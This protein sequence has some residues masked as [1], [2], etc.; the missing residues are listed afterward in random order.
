L[1]LLSK[2]GGGSSNKLGSNETFQYL[3]KKVL[4]VMV[5]M[6]P[7]AREI[8]ID[9]TIKVLGC[10]QEQTYDGIQ[11]PQ[12]NQI[13]YIQSLPVS[14]G[15]YIPVNSIDFM[16]NLKISPDSIVGKF[17]YE[18][19]NP[20]NVLSGGTI[21]KPYGGTKNYPFNKMLNLRMDSNNIGRNYSQDFGAFYN[22]TSGQKLIDISYTQQNDLGVSGDFFRVFLINRDVGT[23]PSLSFRGD[24]VKQFLVDYYSTIKL[25]DPVTVISVL[26]NYASNFISIKG[27]FTYK[28]LSDD[29]A[30]ERILSRVL[31]LCN[32]NRREIDVSGIAKLA[33][34]D[35]VDDS[36]FELNEVDLRNIE[37]KIS[38]I[39]LGIVQYESCGDVSLPVPVD[40]LVDNINDLREIS[41]SLNPEEMVSS[42]EEIIDGY[43]QNPSWKPLLPND[44]KI[45]I[46]INKDIIKD[47]PKAIASSI[48]TPKILLPVFVL[49]QS[50]EKN[51]K[52]FVNNQ[53]LSANTFISSANT[54]VNSGNSILQS[55]NT[56]GQE[57]DNII[58]SAVDF[59]KKFKEYV[60]NI[61]QKIN[62][63]FLKELFDIL[64]KD[65]LNL[66]NI[67]ITDINRSAA[68]KKYTIILRL[69]QLALIVVQLVGNYRRCKNLID[70]ILNLLKLINQTA[71]GQN[72]IPTTL[73]PLTALLPG[74]SPERATF[75]VLEGLQALGVPTGPLP[76][77]SP[78]IVNQL[79]SSVISGMDK[80]ESENG[81]IDAMVVV[82]PIVGG[83][84]QV[85]GKKR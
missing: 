10:S 68:L 18:K 84:L 21:F 9:E 54:T 5:K 80:E 30:F 73:L 85:Y 3:R 45:D 49:L 83:L 40:N 27:G 44:V 76:D 24:T 16:G 39:Q 50:I 17:F 47:L 19:E 48:L 15:F 33:E 51:A 36:F 64:K 70:D 46:Q 58:D 25:V 37:K 2:T 43:I 56:I 60:F 12:L 29:S 13:P 65:I 42:I 6:E 26:M 61:L 4:Q 31:G 22:G 78:N 63:E 1:N 57:V 7:K 55:G 69:V 11:L 71:G 59:I 52:N 20:L 72:K 23:N 14:S 35:G 82:P 38:N 79:V 62:Q 34:L 75:N 32:D 67:L 53:I 77:G 74:T 28:K 81:T 41:D 66:L 8:V